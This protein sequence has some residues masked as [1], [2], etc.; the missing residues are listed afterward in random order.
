MTIIAIDPSLSGTG[1]AIIDSNGV[2]INQGKITSNK[3]D[4]DF[5]RIYDVTNALV[6]ESKNYNLEEGIIEAQWGGKNVKT[7]N[8]LVAL[9]GAI[10][11][12][13]LN[14]GLTVSEVY[15]SSWRSHLGLKKKDK[16]D[17]WKQISVDHVNSLNILDFQLKKADNDIA[18]AI[19][20]G[21]AFIKQNEN[22]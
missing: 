1:W 8:L 9:K 5:K 6:K 14:A 21:L 16:N 19:C 15:P 10:V 4:N 7:Q 18:D 20:I 13:L 2:L 12:G 11:Y 3:E 22:I 17:D